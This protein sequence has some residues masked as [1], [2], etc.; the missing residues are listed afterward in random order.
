[1]TVEAVVARGYGLSAQDL[2]A[3][4]SPDLGDRRGFW[5]HFAGDP[6]AVEIVEKVLRIAET[7]QVERS[8]ASS[9]ARAGSVRANHGDSHS[10]TGGSPEALESQ[11]WLFA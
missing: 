5:R 11:M 7:Y 3:I 6:H 8:Q 9:A 4:Y 10:A 1:M 2:R